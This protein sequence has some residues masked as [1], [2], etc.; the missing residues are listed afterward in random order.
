MCQISNWV[1][2]T[3]YFVVI[4]EFFSVYACVSFCKRVDRGN[5]TENLACVCLFFVCM[6]V[7]VCFPNALRNQRCTL[8]LAE[9]VAIFFFFLDFG[10]QLDNKTKPKRQQ[11]PI[12]KNIYVYKKRGEGRLVG[13]TW[14]LLPS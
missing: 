10:H 8:A 2:R 4:C 6:C 14:W 12:E 3:S 5:E 1:A 7:C 11:R 13:L 9:F